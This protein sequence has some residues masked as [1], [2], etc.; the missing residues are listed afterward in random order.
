MRVFSTI[1]LIEQIEI[2]ERN[3]KQ[4]KTQTCK[5]ANM[6]QHQDDLK[7][8]FSKFAELREARARYLSEN[9]KFVASFIQHASKERD[10]FRKQST[11]VNRQQARERQRFRDSNRRDVAQTLQRN[12]SERHWGGRKLHRELVSCTRNIRWS[13]SRL[14]RTSAA[15]RTRGERD[16]IRETSEALK[17]IQRSVLRIRASVRKSSI[18]PQSLS[19]LRGI[20]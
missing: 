15:D 3:R 17:K 4:N 16:R 11:I 14:L 5:P 10:A 19:R 6:S 8:L 12:H 18:R 20:L 13:V 1:P 7:S 2:T 9:R